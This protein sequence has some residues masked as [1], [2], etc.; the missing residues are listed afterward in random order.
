MLLEAEFSSELS[1]ESETDSDAEKDSLATTSAPKRTGSTKKRQKKSYF[2]IRKRSRR[3]EELDAREEAPAE[4]DSSWRMVGA[5]RKLSCILLNRESYLPRLVP[6]VGGLILVGLILLIVYLAQSHKSLG[7]TTNVSSTNTASTGSE[8]TR[9]QIQIIPKKLTYFNKKKQRLHKQPT[10]S[11]MGTLATRV[12]Q[13]M[14]TTEEMATA[15]GTRTLAEIRTLTL[16]DQIPRITADQTLATMEAAQ[17]QTMATTRTAMEETRTAMEDWIVVEE[18]LTAMEDRITVEGFQRLTAL[19]DQILT[20]TTKIQ[21][22]MVETA[23][24]ATTRTATQEEMKSRII[25][26]DLEAPITRGRLGI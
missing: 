18:T 2:S 14:E 3:D 19:A 5:V 25:P 26:E 17:A 13:E 15:Q 1:S 11:T 22:T 20:A 7:N 9:I 24:L 10:T 12:I 16:M 23:I 4:S 6:T 21:T 8:F